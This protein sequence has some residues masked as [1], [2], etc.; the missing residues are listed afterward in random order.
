MAE[1]VKE[2]TEMSKTPGENA[3]TAPVEDKTVEQPSETLDAEET[4]DEALIVLNAIDQTIGGKGEIAEIPAELRGSIKSL[5]ENLVFVREMFE[6]PLWKSIL[7]DM[8]DQKEDGQTPSLE[9]AVARNIPLEKIQTLSESEDYAGIQ[10]ELA[11]S[12]QAK[13]TSEEED[14]AYEATFE[15]S[16]K[17]GEEYAAEMGYDEEERNELFQ[18]V[19]DLF[20][21]MADGK[22]TKEEF[23]K[24]DKMR[25]YDRDIEDMRSQITTTETK[26]VLPDKASVEASV[27]KAKETKP[28]GP[29]NTPGMGSMSAYDNATTDVTQIGKRKRI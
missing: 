12:L 21:V 1:Q 22:L 25:N 15:D 26:E 24:V 9:V 7:D 4:I 20:S 19:L 28:S 14:A 23:K 29:V 3:E 8:A 17:A 27:T 16:K 18:F 5:V 10:G 2:T 6:D 11:S 13:K